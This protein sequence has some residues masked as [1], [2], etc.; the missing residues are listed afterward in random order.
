MPSFCIVALCAAFIAWTGKARGGDDGS[1]GSTP[2]LPPPPPSGWIRGR[3]TYYGGPDLL[4]LAYDPSRGNGSFGI[5]TYG[6]CGYT[7]SDGTLP[8]AQDAVAAASDSLP[9]YPGSCGR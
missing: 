8:F 9:D 6:S 7:N 3:T 2:Q 4:A 5:L 1:S